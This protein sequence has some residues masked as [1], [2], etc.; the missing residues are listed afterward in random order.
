MALQR[1]HSGVGLRTATAFAR[2]LSRLKRNGCNL[3]VVGNGH[4][5]TR[6]NA[7]RRLLGCEGGEPR[8]RLVVAADSSAAAARDRLPA[9]STTPSGER[10][11]IIDW[12]TPTRSGAAVAEPRPS[13]TRTVPIAADDL[14]GLGI[15]IHETVADDEHE[16]AQLRLCFDS[17]TPLIARF[18]HETVFRFLH[19][20]T[21]LIGRARGMGHYHLP[22]GRNAEATRTVAP[23]FDAIVELRT[24]GGRPE[25]RWH[26]PDED[27]VTGWLAV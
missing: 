18:D 10:D 22:V 14:A 13:G 5:P 11:T 20:V 1:E 26:V 3:L 12:E 9:A 8:R 2:T 25:Q 15:E 21:G 23:L 7:C 17:L 16:P 19:L 4:E 24:E 6:T 27:L